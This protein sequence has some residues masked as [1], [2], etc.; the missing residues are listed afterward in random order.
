MIQLEGRLDTSRGM[1]GTTSAHRQLANA[2]PGALTWLVLLSAVVGVTLFPGQWLVVVTVFVAWIVA[3]M[4]AMFAGVLVGEYKLR[5]WA[6]TDWTAAEDVPVPATGIAPNDVRHVVLVPNFREPTAVLDRTLRA[7]SVQH[8]ATERVIVVLAMEE[9]EKDARVKAQRVLAGYEH[10]FLGTLVTL[11]PANLPGEVPGKSSNQ[12]WAAARARE[13]LSEQGINPEFTTITSCDSD[14]LL[15]PSYFAALSR[16]FA[17]DL[18]RHRRFWQA[19]IRYYNNL[20]D[21]PFLLRLDL[22][23]MHTGQLSA[24]ALPMSRP[25]PVS[26]YSLSMQLAEEVGWWDPAVIA[27]DWHMYLRSFIVKH[28]DVRTVGVFL[29]TSSDIVDGPT[30][31]S[32]V[33]ARYVQVVR[34]AWGA[35]DV[36]YLLVSLPKSKVSPLKRV[37]ILGHVLHDHVL[38]ATVFMMLFSGTFLTWQIRTTH[39]IIFLWYWFEVGSLMR[40]LYALASVL[41]VAAIG[42][43]VYRRRSVDGTRLDLVAEMVGSWIL[44]PLVGVFAGWVPALHAQTKLMLGM[45]LHYTVAPKRMVGRP[46]E[47]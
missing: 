11:H 23:F 29:P 32:A 47:T 31:A 33:K 3:R 4:A 27:E 20:R 7:L 14:S 22:V 19:P 18:R 2:V 42:L 30:M 24:L 5:R 26:T 34:H 16:L 28:G 8:R 17:T 21:V 43:E 12:A 9:R 39:D 37:F 10:A 1:T 40:I 45:P 6:R 41:F 36:G 13:Y 44:L 35:E 15:H 38:R 25:L 46:S